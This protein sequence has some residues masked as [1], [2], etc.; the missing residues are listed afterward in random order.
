MKKIAAIIENGTL[1]H[2]TWSIRCAMTHFSRLSRI[3]CSMVDKPQ[4][5]NLAIGHL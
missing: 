5:V 3:R 1:K 2:V 4:D